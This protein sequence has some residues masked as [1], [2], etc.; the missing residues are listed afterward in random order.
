[1]GEGVRETRNIKYITSIGSIKYERKREVGRAT[2]DTTFVNRM[3][4]VEHRFEEIED[5][6][7][8]DICREDIPRRENTGAK[9]QVKIVFL[10]SSRS[11]MIEQSE[12]KNNCSKL[13]RGI[14][15]TITGISH[16]HRKK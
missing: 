14:I 9:L 16:L 2:V 13:C 1:M 11:S 10:V 6:S 12:Q 4:W 8:A 15:N 7:P 5:V 3:A